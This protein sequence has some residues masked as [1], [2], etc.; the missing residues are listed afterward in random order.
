MVWNKM[1]GH[2]RY[3]HL[4]SPSDL[5]LVWVCHLFT[6]TMFS[7][8]LQTSVV[9]FWNVW[10]CMLFPLKRKKVHLGS[11]DGPTGRPRS[12]IGLDSIVVRPPARRLLVSSP[13]TRF[14]RRQPEPAGVKM[15]EGFSVLTS[16]IGVELCTYQDRRMCACMICTG[17]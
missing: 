7:W 17:N 10:A 13:A 9:V 8:F 3:F 12:V 1:Y 14:L 4:H 6:V 11:H 15:D 16:R 5:Q 2:A